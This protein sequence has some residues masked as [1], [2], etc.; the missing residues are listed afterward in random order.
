MASV[1]T[2]PWAPA[3]SRAT[4]I[5]CTSPGA[6]GATRPPPRRLLVLALLAATRSR[7]GRAPGPWTAPS[8]PRAGRASSAPRPRPCPLALLVLGQP[9]S[10][11]ASARRTLPARRSAYRVR[12]RRARSADGPPKW[13]QRLPPPA[14]LRGFGPGP[15]PRARGCASHSASISSLLSSMNAVVSA[16][17]TAAAAILAPS[18]PRGPSPAAGTATHAARRPRTGSPVRGSTM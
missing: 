7:R 14:V 11:P 17:V 18:R 5:S 6:A 8:A 2:W 4:L 16:S 12:H 15:R 9:C 13:T 3:P 10:S 1:S